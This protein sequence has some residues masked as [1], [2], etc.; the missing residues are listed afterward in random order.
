MVPGLLWSFLFVQS[1][2]RFMP[3]SPLHLHE[4]VTP[5]KMFNVLPAVDEVSHTEN[6]FNTNDVLLL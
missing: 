4:V 5:S 3:R 1:L 6:Y 2:H